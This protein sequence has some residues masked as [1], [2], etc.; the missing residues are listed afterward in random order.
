MKPSTST[1][2]QFWKHLKSRR[3]I[4]ASS[5]LQT[6]FVQKHRRH[7][8]N[9]KNRRKYFSH[10]ENPR[11]HQIK[12]LKFSARREITTSTSRLG[13][14]R[15]ILDQ[16]C[17]IPLL[18]WVSLTRLSVQVSSFRTSSSKGDNCVSWRTSAAMGTPSWPYGPL[19]SVTR[20]TDDFGLVPLSKIR[21]S[22]T[23]PSPRQG[24]P[25][26]REYQRLKRYMERETWIM[27][28][29]RLL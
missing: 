7:K 26:E 11:I 12:W 19:V 1:L 13:E 27:S 2:C 18:N 4:N 14:Q 8:N 15:N 28:S 6:W 25:R 24:S 16:N 29:H 9:T 22:V 3:L 5:L 17:E 23:P 10:V 20:P 21:P